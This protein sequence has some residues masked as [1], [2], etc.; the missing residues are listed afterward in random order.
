V[1]EDNVVNQMV[2]RAT[3][4]TRGL[5]VDVVGD[6]EEAVTAAL[7]GNDAAVFMDCQMPVMDGLEATRRIRAC[8]SGRLPIIAM[9]AGAFQDDRQACLSAGM[10]DFLPK[11]WTAEELHD[12]LARLARQYLPAAA[13]R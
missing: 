8:E 12:V 9:T 10:D 2:A 13:R 11:P 5:V 6:G 4:Q 1:A 3:F 7:S